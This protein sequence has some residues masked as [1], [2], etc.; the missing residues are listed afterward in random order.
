MPEKQVYEYAT[1]RLVPR[2]ER[3]E[4]LNIGV[5]LSCKKNRFLGLKYQVNQERLLA[6][7]PN[8]DLEAVQDYLRSWDLICQ[9]DPAGGP[10]A[11]LVS[12]ERFRLLSAPRSTIIQCSPVHTGLAEDPAQVLPHLF[13][14]YVL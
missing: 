4:F 5:L 7:D 9:G 6:F 1:V 3:E 12:T 8:L 14:Q 10:M 2:V 13:E 11:S